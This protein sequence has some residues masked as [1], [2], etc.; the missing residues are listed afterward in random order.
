MIKHQW[1]FDHIMTKRGI[2]EASADMGLIA[3]AYIRRL[4]NI[5]ASKPKKLSEM[6]KTLLISILKLIGHFMVHF[7]NKSSNILILDKNILKQ[8]NLFFKSL[9]R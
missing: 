3:L 6:W 4:F 8:Q 5:R 1:G 9:L 2:S 7:G